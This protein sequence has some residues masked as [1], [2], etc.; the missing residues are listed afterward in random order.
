MPQIRFMNFNRNIHNNNN[1]VDP[2][3]CEEQTRH[4]FSGDWIWRLGSSI[5]IILYLIYIFLKKETSIIFFN[6]VILRIINH[7]E[8]HDL[9]ISKDVFFS[10]NAYLSSSIFIF[11]S[12]RAH[13]REFFRGWN[14]CS[15]PSLHSTHIP[16]W[17]G[18]SKH[19][20]INN[21]ETADIPK[22]N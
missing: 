9:R 6:N 19:V 7:V 1:I 14:L 8:K 22:F 2:V 21:Y 13:M 3:E 4:S 11:S 17:L 18:I 10:G 12:S 20:H 15:R 5:Y 16:N